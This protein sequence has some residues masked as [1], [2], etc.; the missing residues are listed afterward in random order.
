MDKIID[1]STKRPVSVLMYFSLVIVLG[2]ASVF[3]INTSLLPK[4]KDRWI[5]VYANY[6]GVRAEEIRKLVAIPLEQALASLKD[7]KN[8]ETVSRDGSCED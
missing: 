7:V 4:A 1:F 3:C 2:A 8:I 5:L 6:D